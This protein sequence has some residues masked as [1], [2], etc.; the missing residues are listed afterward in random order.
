VLSSCR[1][2]CGEAIYEIGVHD[3]GALLVRIEVCAQLCAC[4]H[5]CVGFDRD[6]NDEIIRYTRTHG[7]E[8]EG[9]VHVSGDTVCVFDVVTLARMSQQDRH[10]SGPERLL[11]AR[12]SARAAQR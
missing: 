2:G 6:R 3:S 9:G 11:L 1:E 8:F 7:Q 5:V 4:D 10:N 12:A